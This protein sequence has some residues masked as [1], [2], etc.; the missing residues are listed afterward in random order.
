MMAMGTVLS[1]KKAVVFDTEITS[2]KVTVTTIAGA[3][4]D[5]AALPLLVSLP[6]LP[7]LVAWLPAQVGKV[8]AKD[9]SAPQV[10]VDP[11]VPS[12]Q[13]TVQLCPVVRDAQ[14][15][16]RNDEDEGML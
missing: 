16:I 8:P 9:W 2:P 6:L 7:A 15:G 1:A 13:V 12:G 14:F 3:F 11:P 4:V 5:A 10:N